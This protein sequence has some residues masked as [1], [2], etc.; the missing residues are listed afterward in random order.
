MVA[1]G[2]EVVVLSEDI[3]NNVESQEPELD[4]NE[5]LQIRR[6]KLNALKEA[7]VLWVRQALLIF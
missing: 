5:L 1:F 4:L 3:R 2:K 7:G 6:N